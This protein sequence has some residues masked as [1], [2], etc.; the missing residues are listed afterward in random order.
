MFG[1][2]FE[3]Q[4]LICLIAFAGLTA[5]GGSGGGAVVAPPEPPAACSN[6]G[7]KQFVLDALYDWYLWN[8]L[9]PANIDIS[10]YSS[11]EELVFR[12]TTEFGPQNSNGDPIDF[13]SSVGS[14]DADQ[15]FFGEGKF[16][17]FGFS[18]RVENGNMRI[19]RVFSGS[20]MDAGGVERGHTVVTLN[21]RTFTDIND[22]EGVSAFFD[23][24]ETVTFEMRRLD[25]TVFSSSVTA[26]IVTIP[27]VPEDSVRLIDLGAG[28][29]PLGYMELATFISTANSRF[30]TVF[31]E[32]IAAGVE[33][34]VIDLRYNGGGLVNTAELLGD[35]LGGFANDGFV[36]SNTEFNADRAPV[37]DSSSFFSRQGNSLDTTRFIVIASSGTASASELVTNSLIPYADVWI[38]GDS[39]FG[40]PV[41]QIGLEFCDKI[42][43]PTSFRTTNADG[44]GD[45]FDGL[46]VDCPATDDLD[47]PTGDDNDPNILAARSISLTGGCPVSSLSGGQQATRIRV[48]VKRPDLTGPPAREF[49]DAY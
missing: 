37:Y 33:D 36:F 39:T 25:N 3:I 2:R 22:N 27:P 40:K 13:F 34:V 24:N 4:K 30:D 23:A 48:E 5:C 42:L 11:P 43:R 1:K 16:E 14:L 45:Y 29:P 19:V 41:G 9:L 12:V 20:P 8:D 47:I 10:D 17:G 26:A 35:Y 32:F 28:I 18:W 46:P 44:V 49:A 15:Q 7:Q 38:V 6:D 21:S 31:G